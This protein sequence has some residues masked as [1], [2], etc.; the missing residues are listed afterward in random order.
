VLWANFLLPDGTVINIGHDITDSKQWEEEQQKV[1]KLESIGI[2]AAGIAHNFNNIL[3]VILGNIEIAKMDA[4]QG[5]ENREVLEQAEMASLKAK[6]LTAQLLTFAKGGAPI[7]KITSLAELIKNTA[8]SALH[9][10]NVKCHFSIAA[11]LRQAEIDA[12]QVRQVIHNLTLNARQAM[13]AGGSIELKAENMTISTTNGHDMK[14][15]LQAGDYVMI[16]VTD[17]GSGIPEKNM[18]KIFDPFF[19]TKAGAVGLGLATSFSIVRRHG[20]HISVDSKAGA[21][22]TVYVYLPVA[23]EIS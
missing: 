1:A 18:G 12:V 16:S 2:L 19:T 10:S 21:G 7:K 5:S 17:H 23:G 13:P 6:D 20:G 14:L 8:D 9:G 22:S 15:M 11:A 3:T 4:N